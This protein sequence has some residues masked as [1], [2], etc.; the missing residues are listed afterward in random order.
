MMPAIDPAYADYSKAFAFERERS[1]LPHEH[2][3]YVGHRLRYRT[4]GRGPYPYTELGNMPVYR[5]RAI[6]Q[7]CGDGGTVL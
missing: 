6:S 1:L 3:R 4:V 2:C 5:V 7:P